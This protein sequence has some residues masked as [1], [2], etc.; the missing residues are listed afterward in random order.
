MEE[1]MEWFKKHVDTVIVLGGIV[2]SLLWMNHRFTELE[3][4]IVMIKTVMIMSK[5]M[6]QEL[7]LK[8]CKEK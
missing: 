2:S 4:D 7:A 3:K 8:D 6:P 5:V 1:T